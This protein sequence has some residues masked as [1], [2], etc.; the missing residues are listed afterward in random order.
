MYRYVAGQQMIWDVVVL[1]ILNVMSKK[2]LFHYGAKL[3][4]T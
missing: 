3:I 4:F 1:I 2:N